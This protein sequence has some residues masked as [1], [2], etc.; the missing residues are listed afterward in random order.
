MI[1][2]DPDPDPDPDS[3]PGSGK[4]HVGLFQVSHKCKK[5]PEKLQRYSP[6][7]G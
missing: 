5:I 7:K 6:T 4:R 2:F 1:E 3:D